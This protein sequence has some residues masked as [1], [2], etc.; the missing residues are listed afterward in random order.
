MQA[1]KYEGMRLILHRILGALF[2]RVGD[3]DCPAR[4]LWIVREVKVSPSKKG[5][6]RNHRPREC[7]R[8]N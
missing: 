5:A 1:L 3:S 8:D 6:A 2:G 7:D 4:R